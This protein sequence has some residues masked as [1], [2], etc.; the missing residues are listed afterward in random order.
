MSLRISR[1]AGLVLAA[2]A[3]LGGCAGES[4][5]PEGEPVACA[6]GGAADFAQECIFERLDESGALFAIHH[7]DGAFRRFTFDMGETAFALA[8]G[9][10]SLS[11]SESTEPGEA[12][13]A[14]GRDRYRVKRAW[15]GRSAE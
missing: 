1:C 10:E 6:L 5:V 2:L 11:V 3:G 4:G 15:L 13:L 12:Q 9:A 8:D 7:P 14:V